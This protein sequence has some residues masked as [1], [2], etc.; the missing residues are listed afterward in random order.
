MNE[1]EY[2]IQER[3]IEKQES[4]DTDANDLLSGKKSRQQLREGN[5]LIKIERINWR[6]VR[7]PKI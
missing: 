5:G 7:A 4:R 6:E 2:S 1:T 3:R